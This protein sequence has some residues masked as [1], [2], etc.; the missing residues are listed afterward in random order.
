MNV[1]LL[2]I[3]LALSPW[4]I[5]KGFSK[6]SFFVLI[7]VTLA[8]CRIQELVPSLEPYPL[9]FIAASLGI[10]S[11]IFNLMLHKIEIYWCQE[12]SYFSAFFFW[13]SMSVVFSYNFSYSFQFWQI[14]VVK[15]AI[16]FFLISWTINEKKDYAWLVL[17][18]IISGII[19]SL[20]VL[21]NKYYAIG[22]V[23]STRA[24]ANITAGLL[25]DPNDLAF[26]LLIPFSFA[27][28]LPISSFLPF[29]IRVFGMGSAFIIANSVIATQSRGGLLGLMGVCLCAFS[30][31]VKRKSIVLFIGALL[32]FFLYYFAGIGARES[33]GS[34]GLEQGLDTSSSDR[35]EAWKAALKMAIYHPILGVGLN[36]FADNFFNYTN[37]TIKKDMATHSSWLSVLSETGFIGF[38]IFLACVY[39]AFK[40]IKRT[41]QHMESNIHFDST[42][43]IYLITSY[44]VYFGL[45]GYCI[46]GTFLSQ[47]Y[48][49]VFYTLFAI[50]ISLSHYAKKVTPNA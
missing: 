1:F 42:N 23:E 37:G 17:I 44:G 25:S 40:S 46:S 50:T 28:A 45:I 43:R 24:S 16:A 8:L 21:Y 38:F 7:F 36:N 18:C 13:I 10:A 6:P 9:V 3:F 12:M 41:I 35:V 47:A 11:L 22:L 49:W 2:F 15:I 5:Y 31:R 39:L 26:T 14:V 29:S 20:V 30:Q 48:S 27:I 32:F 19:T 34:L 33:G 4:I